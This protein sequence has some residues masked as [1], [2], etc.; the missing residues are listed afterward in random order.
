VVF[1]LLELVA[2]TAFAHTG[3]DTSGP[4]FVRGLLH[5]LSGLDHVLAMLA[6][7]M[8]GAQL[9]WPAIWV[10]PVAF[11]MVMA[12]GAAW[13]ILGLPLPAVE[14]GVAFS[15]IVLGSFIASGKRPP[16]V[17]A[18]CV[19]AAFAVFHGYAHGIESKQGIDFASYCLGFVVATGTI[20]LT[21]IGIGFV[22]HLPRGETLL[23]MGGA[24]ISLTGCF[25]VAQLAGAF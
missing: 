21:G 1:V 12:L 14:I 20:H 19:V 15:V 6:V 9:G 13:G 17:L 2:H 7:G 23:R 4:G 18:A 5:P 11:P 3:G 22:T 25:L 8:W 16:L 10:L 24:L